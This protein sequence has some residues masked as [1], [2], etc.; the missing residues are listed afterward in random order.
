[1]IAEE[2][3]EAWLRT[4]ARLAGIELEA[5]QLPG[6]LENF[7]RSMQIAAVV[8]ALELAEQDELAPVWRP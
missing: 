3:D 5:E 7:R 8:T 6:V 2:I 1:M 4:A